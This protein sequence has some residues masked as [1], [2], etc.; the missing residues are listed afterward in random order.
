LPERIQFA[1]R[2]PRVEGY[3]QVVRNRIEVDWEKVPSITLD[4]AKIPSDVSMSAA[5]PNNSGRV[6]AVKGRV[7]E[8][9]IEEF[10]A[11]KRLQQLIFEAAGTL[12]KDFIATGAA[13][14]PAHVLFPQLQK[15]IARYVDE[16]VRDAGR[17]K[18][19]LFCSPYYGWFLER[20][21]QA[22]R[23]DVSVSDLPEAPRYERAKPDGSTADVDFWTS[24][25]VRDTARSHV[26]YLVID[27]KLEA[28]AAAKLDGSKA[29]QAWVKNAQLGL[30]IPY[31]HNGERHDYH[32]DF[33]IRLAGKGDKYLLLETKGYDELVDVK[34]SAAERWCEAVNADGRHGRWTYRIARSVGDVAEFLIQSQPDPT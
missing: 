18:R 2:F 22:L 16:K 14:A 7:S 1:I 11:T 26:N 12:T 9:S 13:K 4:P 21:V 27:S 3:T 6:V 32:P 19:V 34:G 28:Q 15:V 20:L 29:V 31:V 30:T 23:A 5:M 17:D 25:D 33:I 24:R 10:Y 8:M